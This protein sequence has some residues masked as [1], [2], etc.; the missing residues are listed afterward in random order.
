MQ[1]ALVDL[2]PPQDDKDYGL[3]ASWLRPLSASAVLTADSELIT[4]DEL[5]QLNRRG[6]VRHLMVDTVEGE[7]IGVVSWRPLGAPGGFS[8][9]SAVGDPERWS[10]GYGG[11]ATAMI[12]DHLFHACNAHR[13]QVVTAMF[14]KHSVRMAA[15]SA[16][17]LEGILR[18]YYFLDGEYHD[19]AVWSLLRDEYYAEVRR[20]AALN[21][22]FG[23]PD[24]VPAQDKAEARRTLA[25]YVAQGRPTSLAQFLPGQEVLD[26]IPV[27]S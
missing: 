14:N 23:V 9:G 6:T 7:S 17:V 12:V 13:V 16:F 21:P 25:G 26:S 20:V 18:R 24:Q 5:Q 10:A 22:I 4:A 8:I 3:I 2:R 15:R 27:A 11:E 1:G 19:A